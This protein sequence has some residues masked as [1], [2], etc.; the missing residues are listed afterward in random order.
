MSTSSHPGT[1]ERLAEYA[2]LV[3][4]VGTNLQRDQDL[5]ILAQPEHVELV[6][7]IARA[8]YGAGARTVG[9]LY[10]D[11]HLKRAQVQFAPEDALGWTAPWMLAMLDHYDENDGALVSITGDPYP[12]LLGDLDP[13]RLAR[14]TPRA[15]GARLMESINA[16]RMSWTVVAHPNEGWARQV[17]GEPDLDRLWEAV[18][19][20]MRL[21]SDDPTAAWHNHATK[22]DDRAT[23][24]TTRRFDAIRFH[25][26]GTD[27]TVGLSPRA[28]WKGATE[29]TV[30]G[31]RHINNM[32][33]EE[34][35]TT[36]DR[37]R[38]EGTVRSTRPLVLDG[39]VVRDLELRFVN[40]KVVDVQASTGKAFLRDRLNT[41]EGASFL[42]ELA[43]V[44]GESRVGQT[45]IVFC[46]TLF[47]ENATCHIALGASYAVGIKGGETMRPDELEALGFNVSTTHMDFMIGGPEVAVDG[48][49]PDGTVVPILR[50]DVWQLD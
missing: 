23:L 37:R 13:A 8:G 45:G 6:R 4:E 32:P 50:D 21:D 31:V 38:T 47:D 16:R 39:T 34:V 35:F 26:N 17:F 22:L 20:A 1:N 41:D 25:G 44:D 19:N 48:V 43:L 27:L 5:V 14:A 49:E 2:R 18:A 40:G 33:T 10:S 46:E 15:Q 42:G 11:P 3:I 9:A 29:T 30:A 12:E 28:N 24:L 36:P 7:A